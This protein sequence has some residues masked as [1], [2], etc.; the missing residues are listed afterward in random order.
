[1]LTTAYR[2]EG[3]LFQLRI[4][5]KADKKPIDYVMRDVVILFDNFMPKHGRYYYQMIVEMIGSLWW[6]VRAAEKVWPCLSSFVLI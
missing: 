5:E 1:M 4:K 2:E 6:T 3:E